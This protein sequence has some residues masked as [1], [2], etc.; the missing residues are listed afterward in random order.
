MRIMIFIVRFLVAIGILVRSTN[1][2]TIGSRRNSDSRCLRFS[3]G[4]GKPLLMRG[5]AG[6]RPHRVLRVAAIPLGGY[7]KLLDERE[8]GCRPR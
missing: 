7:V 3:I 8:G 6:R 1:S 4:F 2:A 5:R